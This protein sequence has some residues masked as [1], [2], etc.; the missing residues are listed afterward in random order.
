[1]R[2]FSLPKRNERWSEVYHLLAVAALN[3]KLSS[4]NLTQPLTIKLQGGLVM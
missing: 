4:R 3:R 1:M 2:L